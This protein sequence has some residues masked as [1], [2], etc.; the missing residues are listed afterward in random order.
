MKQ[1][2][3]RGGAR[4]RLSLE[5]PL[6][7]FEQEYFKSGPHDHVRMAF[8]YW[9]DVLAGRAPSPVD[10]P[11]PI[12]ERCDELVRLLFPPT[13]RESPE[14]ARYRLLAILRLHWVMADTSGPLREVAR[15]LHRKRR[16]KLSAQWRAFQVAPDI[17]PRLAHALVEAFAGDRAGV[18]EVAR[19]LGVHRNTIGA[20]LKLYRIG[21]R[22]LRACET[23]DPQ[24]VHIEELSESEVQTLNDKT[25]LLAMRVRVQG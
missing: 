22:E 6:L 7:T 25:R 1:P 10:P 17:S 24:L 4:K 11:T 12:R 3:K 8:R 2:V 18:G 15:A 19:A 20:K 21:M 23:C 14:L 13:M 16:R 5:P 9:Q